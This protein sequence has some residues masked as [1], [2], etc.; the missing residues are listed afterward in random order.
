MKE[1]QYP[2]LDG[3]I[4]SPPRKKRSSRNRIVKMMSDMEIDVNEKCPVCGE[5]DTLTRK[6]DIVIKEKM[7]NENIM[8]GNLKGSVCNVCNSIFLNGDSYKIASEIINDEIKAS[9]EMTKTNITLR[10]Y[11]YEWIKKHKAFNFSGFVQESI[12][13]LIKQEEET[14]MTSVL[15][16]T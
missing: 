5:T 15:Q 14:G 8:I 3:I 10:R 6:E 13:K 7:P 12:D 11:Q 4:E 16:G 2:D 1:R 9:L